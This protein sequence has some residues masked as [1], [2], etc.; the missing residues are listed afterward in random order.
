M[1]G[2]YLVNILIGV[3]QL[4]NALSGGDPDE[5]ISSRIGR[6]KRDNG[7]SVP[8]RFPVAKLLDK[9][10]EDIDPNHCLEAIEEDE[11]ENAILR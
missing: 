11:G 8:L 4:F 2:K 9:I 5:T 6:M 7:G 1:I 10:L 3:D